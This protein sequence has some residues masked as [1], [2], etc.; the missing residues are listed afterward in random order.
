MR[1]FTTII[2]GFLVLSLFIGETNCQVTKSVFSRVFFVQYKQNGG[3]TF[4]IEVDGRQYLV[5]AKHV[6]QGIQDKDTIQI[7]HEGQWKNLDVKV[8][9][10]SPPEIDI[11]VLIPPGQLSPSI[12][13]EPTIDNLTLSQQVY[14][15]GFPYGLKQYVGDI[16]NGFPFPLVKSGVC[17]AIDQKK[18]S[19]YNLIY[20]DGMANPGFSGGPLVFKDLRTEKFKIAGVVSSYRYHPAQVVGREPTTELMALENSGILIAYDIGP[21]VSII[22]QHP[23]GPKVFK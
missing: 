9:R 17:S 13:L 10:V 19:K 23:E 6:V 14:F 20:V 1:Y 22:K 7:F 2:V 18:E 15:L 16:N 5:T 4:T 11:V 3:T 8:L 21:A 12:P